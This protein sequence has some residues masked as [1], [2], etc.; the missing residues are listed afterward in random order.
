MLFSSSIDGRRNES[1][2][3]RRIINDQYTKHDVKAKVAITEIDSSE[4]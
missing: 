1:A 3:K 4:P 2:Q